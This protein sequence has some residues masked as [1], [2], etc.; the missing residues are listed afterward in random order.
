MKI[1]DI[2]RMLQPWFTKI[3]NIINRSEVI[4]VD[5]SQPIYIVLSQIRGKPAPEEIPMMQHFGFASK[6]PPG[7]EQLR[8]HLTADPDNPLIIASLHKASQP[9]D[10]TSDGDSAMFDSRGQFIKIRANGIQIQ[11]PDKQIDITTSGQEIKITNSGAD[12]KITNNGA[13]ITI[14]NS[15]GDIKTTTSGGNIEI[16][17]N[18]IVNINAA[19][20]VNINAPITNLG[21]A[22][23][24][25]ARVGDAVKVQIVGGSSEGEHNGT[26]TTGSLTNRSI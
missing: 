17:T 26:I 11:S 7:S 6:P 25:I 19:V 16:A 3:A 15:G 22:G 9:T 14:T 8:A 20:S 18:Q 12:I 13:D 4:K 2:T 24:A 1:E 5:S 21:V 10:L 23:S